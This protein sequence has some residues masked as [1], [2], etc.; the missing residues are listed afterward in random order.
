MPALDGEDLADDFFWAKVAFPTFEAA[1]AEF[2]AVGA[3]DLRR[4]TE[5]VPVARIAIEGWVGGDEDAFDE[6]MIAE[7]PEEFLRRI[8]RALF[9]DEGQRVEFVS[10]AQF[11][12]EGFGEVG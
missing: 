12:A 11:R 8:S 9:A 1:G 4:N 5:G 10:L 2:A 3:A 7:L 6:G